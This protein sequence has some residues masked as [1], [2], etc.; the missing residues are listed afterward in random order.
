MHRG[1]IK[2]ES[3]EHSP[4]ATVGIDGGA[5]EDGLIIKETADDVLSCERHRRVSVGF[6]WSQKFTP[7]FLLEVQLGI[8]RDLIGC[9]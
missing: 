1:V 9:T 5:D 8:G 7:F 6:P 2:Q 3:V 4:P